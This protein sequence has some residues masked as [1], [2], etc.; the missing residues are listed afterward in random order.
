MAAVNKDLKPIGD[1]A[2]PGETAPDESSR[3]LIVAN[4]QLLR[5]PMVKGEELVTVSP[6]VPSGKKTSSA[7]RV[8]PSAVAGSPEAATEP[9][10]SMAVIAQVSDDPEDTTNIPEATPPATTSIEPAPAEASAEEQPVVVSVK[11]KITPISNMQPPAEADAPAQPEAQDTPPAEQNTSDNNSTD[12]AIVDAV[13]GQAADKKKSKDD[14]EAKAKAETLQKLVASKQYFVP[15]HETAASKSLRYGLYSLLAIIIVGIIAG[16]LLI[17]AGLI[18]TS[19][20]PPI[21]LIK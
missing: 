16:D 17:D 10:D 2:K 6:N 14:A 15:I 3:P 4:R 5:D 18:K 12:S 1:I 19:I 21:D 11:K 13:A 20:K 8:E 9:E 7:P